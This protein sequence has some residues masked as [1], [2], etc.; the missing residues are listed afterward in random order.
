MALTTEDT[1][2]LA[3]LK[4]AR[5]RL[6]SGGQ[7]AKVTSGGRTVEYSQADMKRLDGE[8]D[9]LEAAAIETGPRRKR[10]AVTFVFR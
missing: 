6:I 5:D 1:L 4:L 7:V 10:G 3:N 8:I 2:R 9:A